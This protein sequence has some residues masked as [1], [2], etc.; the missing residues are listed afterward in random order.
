MPKGV[1]S[2]LGH[3]NKLPVTDAE[4]SSGESKKTTKNG[5]S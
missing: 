5:Y 4:R 2:S 1:F 3:G